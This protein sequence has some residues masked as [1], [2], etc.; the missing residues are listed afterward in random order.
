MQSLW[1]E[2]EGHTWNL[3]DH[4]SSAPP[5]SYLLCSHQSLPPIS[6]QSQK[7]GEDMN[8]EPGW[9]TGRIPLSIFWKR[10]LDSRKSK[11]PN[12]TLTAQS[13]VWCLHAIP[14]GPGNP[15]L[16]NPEPSPTGT[17]EAPGPGGEGTPGTLQGRKFSVTVPSSHPRSRLSGS[18]SSSATMNLVSLSSHF[19]SLCLF[20]LN[21]RRL[22]TLPTSGCVAT[23][24]HA[25]I[26]NVMRTVPGTIFH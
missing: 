20:P 11:K 26:C 1:P 16:G 9:R 2:H 24:K 21:E 15:F 17:G 4:V 14:Q 23:I 12:S 13:Q 7:E 25:Y 6:P 18:G 22:S 8:H 19:T 5:P 10:S 3:P